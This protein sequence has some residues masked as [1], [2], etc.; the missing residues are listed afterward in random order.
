[1]KEVTQ[2]AVKTCK[3][4]LDLNIYRFGVCG[5]L[6]YLKLTQLSAGG[7][8]KFRSQSHRSTTL[9]RVVGASSSVQGVE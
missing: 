1:M 2:F 6:R 4:Y 7:S 8:L 9:V 3:K 5:A